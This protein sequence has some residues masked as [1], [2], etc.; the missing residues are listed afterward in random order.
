MSSDLKGLPVLSCRTVHV[1][2]NFREVACWCP[3]C[4]KEHVHGFPLDVSARHLERRVP[5]CENYPRGYSLK[6]RDCKHDRT[7]ELREKKKAQAILAKFKDDAFIQV[8]AR[9]GDVVRRFV[10][11]REGA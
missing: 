7:L 3:F 4:R 9:K 5:H 10:W 1:N 8:E 11:Q 6:L 2:S